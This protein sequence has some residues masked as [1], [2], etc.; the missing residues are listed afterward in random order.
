MHGGL[1]EKER[2]KLGISKIAVPLADEKF[3]K[4]CYKLVKKAVAAKHSRRGIKEV[5]KAL[6]KK[7]SG[8]VIIAG[9]VTPIDV[10]THVPIL[11]E[12]TDVPYIYVPSKADLGMAGASKRPTS[13]MFVLTPKDGADYEDL[14][15]KV[16]KMIVAKTPDWL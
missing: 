1:S 14:F 8:V 7:E 13:C 15:K 5:V 4:K 2:V 11:C 16:R 9:N 3:T 6:R 12:E 10:I